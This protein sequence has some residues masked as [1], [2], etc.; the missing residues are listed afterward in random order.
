MAGLVWGLSHG[1][2]EP[3]VLRWGVACGT[4]AA[5][6]NGTAMAPRSLVDRLVQQVQLVSPDERIMN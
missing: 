2:S 1:Y 4:A 5:S 3:E 6:L